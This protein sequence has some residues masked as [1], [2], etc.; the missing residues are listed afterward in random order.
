MNVEEFEKRAESIVD[1]ELNN[2]KT[3]LKKIPDPQAKNEADRLGVSTI[4]VDIKNNPLA[5]NVLKNFVANMILEEV[6]DKSKKI[7]YEQIIK[8]I[9][10]HIMTFCIGYKAALIKP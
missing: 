4:D 1:D 7:N 9:V 3:M 5:Y 10:T 6:S 2:I 8:E